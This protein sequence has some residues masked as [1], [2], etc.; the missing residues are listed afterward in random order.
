MKNIII[1]LICVF[2]CLFAF[3][4]N[5]ELNKELTL[6]RK[7]YYDGPGKRK[8][9]DLKDIP[10]FENKYLELF[11]KYK[12][13]ED[14]INIY[15]SK[16]GTYEYYFK[17]GEDTKEQK[18]IL[19][20][21]EDCYS[22][23]VELANTCNVFMEGAY[24]DWINFLYFKY[25]VKFKNYNEH[26][27]RIIRK[28]IAAVALNALQKLYSLSLNLSEEEV[29]KLR[30]IAHIGRMAY[31]YFDNEPVLEEDRREY[32]EFKRKKKEGRIAEDKLFD[33]KVNNSKR[34]HYIDILIDLYSREPIDNS[35]FESEVRKIVVKESDAKNLIKEVEEKIKPKKQ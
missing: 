11:K 8:E 24:W 16:A 1:V 31:S 13:K 5:E 33:F 22:K 28:K 17:K 20:T 23:A 9:I 26:D 15:L 4:E 12:D 3:A 14:Q 34:P 2:T 6:I 27:F 30:E 10:A 7:S 32:A 29:E 18:D 21:I 19:A 25:E 35:E